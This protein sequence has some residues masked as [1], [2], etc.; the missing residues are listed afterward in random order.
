MNHTHVPPSF[1]DF[2]ILTLELQQF[3]SDFTAKYDPYSDFNFT[4]LFSWGND[5]AEVSLLNGNLVLRMPDYLSGEMSYS[6]L[7]SKKIDESLLELLSHANRL[8]FVP[9]ITIKSIEDPSVFTI[10]EDRDNFDYIYK[11]SELAELQSKDLKKIRSKVNTFEL[12]HTNSKVKTYT[13]STFSSEIIEEIKNTNKKWEDLSKRDDGKLSSE[14]DALYNLLDHSSALNLLLTCVL[15]D[16]QLK[17]FSINEI[18]DEN[19]AICH[20]EKALKDHHT[21]VYP[22]LIR[23]VAKALKSRGIP[24]VNWEQDLGLDG[25]RQSKQSYSPHV[26]FKKYTV[27][28]K[29]ALL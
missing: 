2:T 23:E 14:R 25:L 4:S 21:N 8:D 27:K 13:I 26:M 7:G 16:G 19:Y 11:N 22:Y 9:E 28:P 24:Y 10:H 20:F 12:D 5:E 1:P 29:A 18:L 3:V 17:G 15:V 6:I